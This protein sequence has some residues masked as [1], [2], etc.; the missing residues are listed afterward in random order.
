MN[1]LHER[2]DRLLRVRDEVQ[3]GDHAPDDRLVSRL[4]RL[5]RGDGLVRAVARS[6]QRRHV[7]ARNLRQ[8]PEQVGAGATRFLPFEKVHNLS[9]FRFVQ[10]VIRLFH[11]QL[12]AV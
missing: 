2:H 10:E 12:F 4:E 5:D 11:R 1:R 9:A 8:V 3:V 7:H 6:E